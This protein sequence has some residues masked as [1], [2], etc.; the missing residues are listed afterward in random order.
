MSKKLFDKKK[1]LKITL[2]FMDIIVFILI[3]IF[4]IFVFEVVIKKLLITYNVNKF[5]ENM[6]T[7]QFDLSN[8]VNYIE[9]KEGLP[10]DKSVKT[11]FNYVLISSLKRSKYD[12]SITGI[13]FPEEDNYIKIGKRNDIEVIFDKEKINYNYINDKILEKEEQEKQKK[14]KE[15]HIIFEFNGK[16]YIGLAQIS[17]TGIR[18]NFD[19]ENINLETPILLIADK[20][21][22]FFYL[23][24]NVRNVFLLM[25]FIIFVIGGL[26]KI[27]NT[28]TATKEI[29]KISDRMAEVSNEIKGTGIVKGSLHE[30]IT[31]FKETHNLDSSFIEL[32]KSLV[33]VGDIVSGIA[34]KDLLIATLKNDKSLLDPHDESMAILFLDVQG[35]T[36]IAEK[37]KDKVMNIINHIWIEVENII[38]KRYG[39]INKYEGDACIIIFR[40]LSNKS[41]NPTALNA[42]YS[43]LDILGI[44]PKICK[45]LKI[46]FNFRV[47]FDYGVVT[48]G[49]TGTDNNFELGVI[50]DTV[51]TAARLEA[52]NKQYQT[53]LLLTDN[54][55][56]ATSLEFEKEYNIKSDIYKNFN[57]KFLKVDKARPKGKKEGK[58]LYSII[59]L[60]EKNKYSL[61]GSDMF[62]DK[63]HF[64]YY[65]KLHNSLV[66]N[67][68]FWQKYYSIKLKHPN[69]ETEETINL[70]NDAVEKWSSTATNFAKFY[71][72]TKFPL[73]DHFIQLLLKAEEY[74]E[75]KKRPE[76]WFSKG[77][78]NIKKPSDDW[79]KLGVVELEK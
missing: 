38:D 48:Y 9:E 12:N 8:A 58:V 54:A 19:R 35:F 72:E 29:Y 79:I 1:N 24:N 40:D 43:A 77:I 52:I 65:K 75:F 53:N 2:L 41:K 49:K 78:Y 61:I 28:M 23:I 71:Y 30:L 46:D 18:K 45:D 13:F 11:T 21:D 33:S 64:D 32:V 10:Y 20:E 44:V 16:K 62:F 73:A 36:T 69:E 27:S 66:E 47:G 57:F 6:R 63:K 68:K 55:F 50:G 51:N 60:G 76:I 31:K 4:I 37:Y 14:K 34:D 5:V 15:K 7:T 70:K 26:I 25:L 3:L 74:E 67:I 39:K 22:E 42:F 17:E 56:K 59:K